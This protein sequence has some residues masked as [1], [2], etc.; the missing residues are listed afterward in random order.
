MLNRRVCRVCIVGSIASMFC[1]AISISVAEEARGRGT[2]ES[3]RDLANDQDLR[4]PHAIQRIS[5]RPAR[6]SRHVHSG[7]SSIRFRD[8]D[9]GEH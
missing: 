5:A 4:S 9:H 8:P 6:D 7:L 2:R 1:L 3:K